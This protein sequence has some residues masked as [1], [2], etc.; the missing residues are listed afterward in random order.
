MTLPNYIRFHYVTPKLE[1]TDQPN[2][3]TEFT[4]GVARMQ[5]AD[6]KLPPI[7]HWIRFRKG[8]GPQE[9]DIVYGR[10]ISRGEPTLGGRI[11]AS[12]MHNGHVFDPDAGD[13]IVWYSSKEPVPRSRESQEAVDRDAYVKQLDR[14]SVQAVIVQH[15]R[16][17]HFARWWALFWFLAFLALAGYDGHLTELQIAYNVWIESIINY[18]GL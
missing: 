6:I 14:A 9:S 11:P 12:L 5:V 13:R 4:L 7:G 3:V 18:G 16:K 10:V 17:H 1:I 8:F 15:Q 2:E